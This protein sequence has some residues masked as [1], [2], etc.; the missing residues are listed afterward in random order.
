MWYI[1][2][3][4][5]WHEGGDPPVYRAGADSTKA[6]GMQII[7]TDEN[8]L[9]TYGIKII[10][11]EFFNNSELDSVKV[12]LSEKAVAKLGFKNVRKQ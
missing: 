12:V 10:A 3:N 7:V 1:L 9:K 2:R 8:Y 5:Q 11:G 4:S 6:I